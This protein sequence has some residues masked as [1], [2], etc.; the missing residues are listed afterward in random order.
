MIKN[1]REP[2]VY[3]TVKRRQPRVPATVVDMYPLIVGTGLY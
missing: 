1:Y 3:S 2:N